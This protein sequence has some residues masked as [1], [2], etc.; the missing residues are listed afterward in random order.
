MLKSWRVSAMAD[1]CGLDRRQGE[2]ARQWNNG[3]GDVYIHH[4]YL[5]VDT[6]LEAR[7][8][9]HQEALGEWFA[10]YG[11]QDAKGVLFGGYLFLLQD[12]GWGWQ[13]W[14]GGRRRRLVVKSG[15]GGIHARGKAAW[16]LLHDGAFGSEG[17]RE[18][19]A[20][21]SCHGARWLRDRRAME[22]SV[23]R[24]SDIGVWAAQRVSPGG[25]GAIAVD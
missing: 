25:R 20:S 8:I 14:Q 11:V 9:H 7:W 12:T 21:S 6:G 1:R 22:Q 10:R 24:G 3:R 16:G 15:A 13:G 2:V 19:H 5:R 17:G 4:W 23:R 18:G